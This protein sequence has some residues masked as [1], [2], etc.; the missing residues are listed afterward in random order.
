[1]AALSRDIINHRYYFSASDTEKKELEKLLLSEKKK[2]PSRIPYHFSA[3]NKFPGKFMLSYLPRNHPCYEYVT[4]TPE[5]FRFRGRLHAKLD[6]LLHWFKRHFR[7]SMPGSSRSASTSQETP[8]TAVPANVMQAVNNL[9][10]ISQ[11]Q[12]MS[13]LQSIQQKDDWLSNNNAPPFANYNYQQLSTGASEGQNINQWENNWSAAWSVTKPADNLNKG[14]SVD[15]D[16]RWESP[17]GHPSS[18]QSDQK[19]ESQRH[20]D[21]RSRGHRD[22]RYRSHHSRRT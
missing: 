11:S 17:Q 21:R 14:Y 2:Q 16:N 13:T 18:H 5:G 6:G 7:D 3:S 12:L 22:D 9:T 20:Y 4:V 10:N 19:R 15:R 8:I 1:M